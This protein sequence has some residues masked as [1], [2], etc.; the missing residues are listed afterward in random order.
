[1]T[2]VPDP[3][4]WGRTDGLS[5]RQ[6][7]RALSAVARWRLLFGSGSLT[8]FRRPRLA[9]PAST[10][11][12]EADHPHE[13]PSTGGGWSGSC[14]GPTRRW[15]RTAP[16]NRTRA[17]RSAGSTAPTVRAAVDHQDHLVA[18]GAGQD[19]E[20]VLVRRGA[21]GSARWAWPHPGVGPGPTAGRAPT[22]WR[23]PAARPRTPRPSARAATPSRG[24]RWRSC[25][26]KPEP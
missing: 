21:G 18:A 10:T 9:S 20:G 4:G 13:L 19:V 1:M 8:W 17:S 23:R 24:G 11:E 2:P 16:P 3:Q 12:V 6:P 5:V 26:R 7:V 22:R 15:Y 25:R 14:Q